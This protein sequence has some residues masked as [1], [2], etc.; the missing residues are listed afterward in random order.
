MMEEA[1]D[2]DDEIFVYMGGDQEVPDGVRRVRIHLSVKIIRARA[3]YRRR[4]L[5]YVEFHDGIEII[6]EDAFYWC[7]SL[8]GYAL[9][10]WASRSS[11]RRMMVL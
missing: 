5:I 9:N 3:F 8:S 10:C 1:R 4:N 11:K 6:E 7:L 2:V